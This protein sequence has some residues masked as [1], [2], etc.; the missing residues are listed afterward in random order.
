MQLHLNFD[1]RNAA[2]FRFDCFTKSCKPEA[3]PHAFELFLDAIV[4]KD[5]ELIDVNDMV[6]HATV[7]EAF[8]EGAANNTWVQIEK[9]TF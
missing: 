8:Y 7:M 3:L 9:P 2:T 4:G 1:F 5:V 6:A